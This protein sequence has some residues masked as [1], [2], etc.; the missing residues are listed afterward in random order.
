MH[1]VPDS[2]VDGANMGHTWVLSSPG[3]GGG[4][5]GGGGAPPGLSLATSLSLCILRINAHFSSV[6]NLSR[7]ATVDNNPLSCP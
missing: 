4:G 6:L 3:G 7:A 2:K 1:G 5:G